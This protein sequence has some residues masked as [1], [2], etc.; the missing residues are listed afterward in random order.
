VGLGILAGDTLKSAADAGLPLADITL[1]H[2]KGYF[3]QHLDEHGSQSETPCLWKPEAVL[4]ATEAKASFVIGRRRVVVRTWQYPVQGLSGYVVPVYL[5]D[6]WP[7]TA[8][9]CRFSGSRFD[10]MPAQ[11]VAS[12]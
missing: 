2:R 11:T 12:A 8:R 6:A 9:F 7:L 10:K 3:D 1:L 5:L 4:E